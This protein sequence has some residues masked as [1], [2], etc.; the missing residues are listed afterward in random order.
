[1]EV[2]GFRY[3]NK[4]PL[5]SNEFYNPMSLQFTAAYIRG[6]GEGY[7]GIG[8]GGEGV[9]GDFLTDQLSYALQTVRYNT[10]GQQSLDVLFSYTFFLVVLLLKQ[11]FVRHRSRLCVTILSRLLVAR[12]RSLFSYLSKNDELDHLSA[13]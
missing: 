6:Y 1:M 13:E 3:E 9:C 10:D 2:R 5:L 4:I 7:K 8:R 12:W 11:H